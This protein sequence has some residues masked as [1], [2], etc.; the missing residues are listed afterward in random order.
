[1]DY[2]ES[3]MTEAVATAAP[4]FPAEICSNCGYSLLGLPDD[5]VCP[6]CGKTVDRSEIVFHG[7]ARGRHETAM[8][9]KRSRLAWV[10]FSAV[11]L[12]GFNLMW[13]VIS[14]PRFTVILLGVA[15]LPTAYLLFRRRQV[16]HPGLV[17]I[18]IN[19]RGCVQF[20]DLS[21]PSI[22]H[23]NLMSHGWLLPAIVAVVLVACWKIGQVGPVEFWIWAPFCLLLTSLGW[24]GCRRVRRRVRELRHGSIVDINLAYI[25]FTEW[26]RV[27]SFSL[28]EEGADVFRLRINKLT[29]FL[30]IERTSKMPVD[31]EVQMSD[32]QAQSLRLILK[33]FIAGAARKN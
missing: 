15:F 25:K 29:R 8:N 2:N 19:E 12:A 16:E 18:R 11:A 23:D 22:I 30:S 6:E 1:M 10:T 17:Q 3:A 9:A 27:T 20:D 14:Y 24:V 4:A 5:C 21:G 32:E 7:Y 28:E 33:S 26:G 13:S 31:A